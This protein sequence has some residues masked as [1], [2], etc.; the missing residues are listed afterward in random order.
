M[1]TLHII[2]NYSTSYG[3][4]AIAC[5]EIAEGLAEKNISTTVVTSNLDHPKGHIN[6]PANLP[7]FENKVRLIYSSISFRP[8]V[9][10]LKMMRSLITEIK[11]ADIIHIHGLYRFP[12]TFAGW[13]ARKCNKP[14]IISPHGSLDPV[15][16]N[17]KERKIFKRLYE[18]LFENKNLK[19]ANRIHFTADEEMEL[20]EYLNIDKKGEVIK[21]GIKTADYK[22]LPAKGFFADEYNVSK[23]DYKILFLGRITW[24]KG[25]DILIKSLPIIKKS[26][27]NFVLLIVG[28]DNEGYKAEIE[29][30]IHEY[31]MND[32]VKFIDLLEKTEVIKAYVDSDIFV[33]PSYSENFGLTIVESMACGCPVVISRNV[34]IHRNISDGQYGYVIDCE[35]AQIANAVIDY[36]NLPQADKNLLM[37]KIS[38]HAHENYD[39]DKLINQF[40]SLYQDTINNH[41]GLQN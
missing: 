37:D 8:L 15:I 32:H 9:A 31:D 7:I 16:Y 4:M 6:K 26:I 2:S 28:P 14:Y 21:N 33:L 24:K 3:G 5:K 17:K 30:M 25:L 10:S 36:F 38:Q 29:K 20:T 12:Q 11:N 22:N 18:I 23:E 40:I 35:P 27:N 41:S 19:M 39:W 34:N 1:K 13:Y